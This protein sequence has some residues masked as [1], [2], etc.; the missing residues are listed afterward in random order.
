LACAVIVAVLDAIAEEDLLANVTEVSALIRETC[1]C[2]PVTAIQGAGFLLG[3]RTTAPAASVR[4]ALLDRDILVG[5]SSDPYVLRLLPALI[6]QPS[7]VK[8]LAQA[9]EELTDESL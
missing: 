4:D 6:L 9:L 1:I 3:L 8:Q 5:T 2:G 7:H